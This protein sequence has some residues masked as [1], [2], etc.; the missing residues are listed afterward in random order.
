[1][2]PEFQMIPKKNDQNK[3]T[4][5]FQHWSCS[6]IVTKYFKELNWR[7]ILKSRR[8]F[9]FTLNQKAGT[10]LVVC[11][12]KVRMQILENAFTYI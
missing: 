3:I 5:S 7:C 11:I 12:F 4:F 10:R 2:I 8:G 6:W 1:M 9:C